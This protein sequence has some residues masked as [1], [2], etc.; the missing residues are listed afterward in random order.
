[1]KQA[2]GDVTETLTGLP[3]P[4]KRQ[5]CDK[6]Q[7]AHQRARQRMRGRRGPGCGFGPGPDGGFFEPDREP[8][9]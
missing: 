9:D 4:D 7:S 1:M 5:F 3:A 2:R 6:L 8:L